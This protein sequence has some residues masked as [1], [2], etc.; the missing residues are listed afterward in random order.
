MSVLDNWNEWKQ[1]LDG[2]IDQAKEGGLSD[3]VISDIAYQVGEYLASEVDPKNEQERVMSD[4]W[5]AADPEEQKAIAN[6][7]VKLVQNENNR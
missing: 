6:V 5:K 7:M 4:L 2:K 1:F 3:Q